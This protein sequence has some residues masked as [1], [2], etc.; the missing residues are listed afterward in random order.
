VLLLEVFDNGLLLAINPAGNPEKEELELCVH[1]RE[2]TVKAAG[3]EASNATSAEL[4]GVTGS[5]ERDSRILASG[6]VTDQNSATSFPGARLFFDELDFLSYPVY[7]P[8][9]AGWRARHDIEPSARE[10]RKIV[11]QAS[12]LLNKDAKLVGH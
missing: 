5:R 12:F 7:R 4:F 8:R 3:S 9:H 6:Q 10:L 11:G 1:G 2:K